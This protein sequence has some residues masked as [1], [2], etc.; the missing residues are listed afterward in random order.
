LGA[1]EVHVRVGSPPITNPCYFGID[2]PNTKLLIASGRNVEEIRIELG[3]STL[4]YIDM[5]IIKRI[6]GD[7]NMCDGCFSGN[8]PNITDW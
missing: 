8:Y 1:K 7:Y 4:I 5:N 6:I 2:I 3:C